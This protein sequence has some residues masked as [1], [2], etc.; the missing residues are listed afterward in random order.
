MDSG[1]KFCLKSWLF[2]RAY[3][4]NGRLCELL[5]KGRYIH[6]NPRVD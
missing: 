3:T 6:V 1:F 4:L 2:E 5:L